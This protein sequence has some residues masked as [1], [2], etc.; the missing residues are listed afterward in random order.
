MDEFDWIHWISKKAGKPPQGWIGIGD[1]AAVF[2]PTRRNSAIATDVIVE[3]VD[4]DD[5]VSPKEAGHK[6]LAINL[7]DMAAM[8]TKP[9]AF[10]MTLGVTENWNGPKLKRFLAG[11]FQT[12]RKHKVS[13][14]GGDMTS[15]KQFFCSITVWGEMA[16]RRPISRA[17]ARVDDLIMVTGTL[18]GSILKKH[19]AFTPRT[20]ESV[21][22]SRHFPPTSMIDV[23]DGLMQ[24]LKHILK[25]SRCGARIELDAIPV[26]VDSKVKHKTK[27]GALN[28]ALSDGE[29]FEL[30][31]TV[32]P[33]MLP[34]LMTRW[35]KAFPKTQLT[36]IGRILSESGKVSFFK[37]VK[38]VRFK[39]SPGF[40]HF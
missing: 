7:S 16:G 25:E 10:L 8:G 22:L 29:D 35:P 40:R 2:P 19:Y 17:G 28:G 14:V 26:S 30:L 21:W 36:A 34:R 3:G 4:F 38:P 1:D 13:C 24:D 32:R 6:A 5:S 20:A 11:V 23:S 33:E 9:T 27:D 18:G 12:A 31:L 15:A 37:G 39:P